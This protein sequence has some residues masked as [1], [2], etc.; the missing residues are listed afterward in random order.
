MSEPVYGQIKLKCPYKHELDV[1]F[2]NPRHPV[3]KQTFDRVADVIKEPEMVPVNPGDKNG[4][5]KPVEAELRFDTLGVV[6][7]GQ[8]VS[9]ECQ[10]CGQTWQTP[11]EMVE[12]EIAKLVNT[13]VVT[14]TLYD[15]PLC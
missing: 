5:L 2:V 10:R 7:Q 9:A 11:W 14:L 13:P 1:I 3:R 6:E 12:P 4:E 15:R 8:P